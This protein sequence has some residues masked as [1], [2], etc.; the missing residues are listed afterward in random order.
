MYIKPNFYKQTDKRWANVS[1]NGA[2]IAK[3]GCG[4]TSLANVISVLKD[5]K[6]TPVETFRY[7]VK[8][9]YIFSS[10]GTYWSGIT[11][12]L[13]HYGIT[14]FTV[15]NNA[16]SAK[17]SLLKG[18][19]VIGTVGKSRWTNGGHYI[20]LYAIE[21]NKCQISD[22]ASSADYRQKDGPWSEYAEA[23]YEQWISIDP[24][25]YKINIP[26]T[27]TTEIIMYVGDAKA[28]IRSGRGLKYR[29]VGVVKRGKK[30]TLYSYKSGWYRIKT[31]RYKGYYISEKVLSK[32]K[33]HV[34]KYKLLTNMNVRSG[35]T[36]KSTILKV[37]GKGS[38]VK[39]SKIKG[40]WIYVPALKGWIRIKDKT[41][42]YLK[43]VK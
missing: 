2:T 35:Y 30:F 14:K 5:P 42:T 26:E 21:N 19:W 4:P 38:I 18:K 25:D 12:V 23:E 3:N 24:K 29:T 39:S 37:L 10:T 15:T 22:S 9:N 11:D 31:G 36:T 16:T 34:A 40:D 1:G 7:L 27:T 17:N 6:I 8:H 13:K 33:P 32:Y 28:N 43:E 41:R 20:L